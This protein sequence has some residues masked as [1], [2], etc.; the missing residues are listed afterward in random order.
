MN[1][2]D[3]YS[4]EGYKKVV[5]LEQTLNKYEDKLGGYLM[6]LTVA[7]VSEEQGKIIN[8]ALQAISDFEKMSDYAL[9]I[10]NTAKRCTM[11]IK[12][13]FEGGG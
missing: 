6:K 7:G 3:S 1:L 8:K 9:E 11:P 4:S 2:L 10:A 12:I 5:E 13:F